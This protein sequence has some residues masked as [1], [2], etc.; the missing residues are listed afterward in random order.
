MNRR[1]LIIKIAVAVVSA[2]L[3]GFV[4]FQALTTDRVAAAD[5]SIFGQ[6]VLAGGMIVWF[7][8]IPL[9]I[10]MLYFLAEHVIVI[11]KSRLVPPELANN[12]IATIRQFGIRQLPARIA[13]NTDM[14]SIALKKVLAHTPSDLNTL[15]NIAAESLQSQGATLMRK[16][17]WHNIIG[18]ISPML[19]LFGTVLGMIETFSTMG[20]AQGQAHPSQLAHGISIAWVTT[21]WGLMTAI[22]AIAAHGILRNRVEFIMGQAADQTESVFLELRRVAASANVEPGRTAAP[23]TPAQPIY[24]PI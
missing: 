3:I 19:G 21:F 18:N 17:E 11:R 5:K 16:I 20:A 12:V 7:I 15:E 23:I 14:V 6:F 8:Q 9:S 10:V 13:R 4:V 1:N 24:N 2:I 22:P